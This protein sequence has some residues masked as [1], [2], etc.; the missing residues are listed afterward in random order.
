MAI[1]EIFRVRLMECGAM[2]ILIKMRSMKGVS[3]L[4]DLSQ[5]ERKVMEC[6]FD[7]SEIVDVFTVFV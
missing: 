3:S 4:R 1:V 2:G 5:Q 7:Q 6:V